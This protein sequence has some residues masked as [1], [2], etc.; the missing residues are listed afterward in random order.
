M[1]PALR[2]ISSTEKAISSNTNIIAAKESI[3]EYF[4][5]FNSTTKQTISSNQKPSSAEKS[6]SGNA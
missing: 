2:V 1:Y 4:F 3:T 6:P 5:C